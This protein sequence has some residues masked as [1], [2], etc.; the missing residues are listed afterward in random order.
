MQ[1]G[2]SHTH[3]HLRPYGAWSVFA[4]VLTLISGLIGM[5]SLSGGT[6]TH[7][8][9]APATAAA[10]FASGAHA[11]E[12]DGVVAMESV[13]TL[14]CTGECGH[15]PV[16]GHGHVGMLT[17]CILAL[18]IGM[19]VL[20]RLPVFRFTRIAALLTRSWLCYAI[21]ASPP[22][23]PPAVTIGDVDQPYLNR[24]GTSCSGRAH[25]PH[26]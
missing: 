5:H 20:L 25:S 10:V 8:S 9:L 3:T 4:V 14:D 22:A 6:A 16:L 24:V 17:L 15:G 12:A 1:G 7:D 11:A 18:L 2:L 21:A 26:L 13:T 19:L 23:R